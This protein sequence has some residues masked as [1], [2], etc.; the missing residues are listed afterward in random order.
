[1]RTKEDP[2]GED[3]GARSSSLLP[4]HKL[5]SLDIHY[6]LQLRRDVEIANTRTQAELGPLPRGGLSVTV[7]RK[8]SLPGAPTAHDCATADVAAAT[9]SL[10]HS[11]TATSYDS[12]ETENMTLR[13]LAM[14]AAVGAATA[15]A[16]A[17]YGGGSHSTSA[18]APTAAAPRV[19][20]EFRAYSSTPVGKDSSCVV[21][22]VADEDG[23]YAR[24]FVYLAKAE[25]RKVRWAKY[26]SISE[27]NYEGR[28]THCLSSGDHIYVLLQVDT[29]APRSLSQTLLS[30]V[31]LRLADGV[32]VKETDVLVP[33][34]HGNYSA[35]VKRR[36]GSFKR[37][38]DE[39]VVA[40]K[41]RYM[42]TED[43][44]PFSA[45]VKP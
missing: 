41:Y 38:N 19:P 24:P 35:W 36:D 4:V 37:V 2:W 8:P 9:P 10:S 45:A 30:V 21:G 3:E 33:G 42:D 15:L 22:S 44:L 13:P 14:A 11:E 27:E 39:L 31:K 32:V 25:G 26:L 34:T 12:Q 5:V 7:K 1:M 29:Q 17:A 43:D 6:D 23:M 40:G 28:A 16:G 20:E 18:A